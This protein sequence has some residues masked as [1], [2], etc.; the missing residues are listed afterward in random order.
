[1][2]VAN[3]PIFP[4]LAGLLIVVFFYSILAGKKKPTVTNPASSAD[5]TTL[6]GVLDEAWF[7]FAN[8]F[9][10]SSNARNLTTTSVDKYVK[11]KL[12]EPVFPSTTVSGTFSTTSSTK[13]KLVTHYKPD[14]TSGSFTDSYACTGILDDW[15]NDIL[16]NL[17]TDSILGI[18]YISIPDTITNSRLFVAAFYEKTTA[19][20]VQYLFGVILRNGLSANQSIVYTV[21]DAT[22]SDT[23]DV[24]DRAITPNTLWWNTGFESSD[25]NFSST[26]I[27]KTAAD[28]NSY[29][30]SNDFF[31][32]KA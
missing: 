25:D 3:F 24:E 32:T 8:A 6:K 7:L 5:I 31:I 15:Q 12:S 4:L 11:S 27:L 30:Q 19:G 26:T 18:T 28:D 13:F 20:N 17:S 14:R 23:I 29:P 10:P 21:G 16:K 9:S 22:G 1:M 2:S